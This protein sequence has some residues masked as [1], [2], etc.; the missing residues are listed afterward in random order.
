MFSTPQAAAAATPKEL[1]RYTRYQLRSNKGPVIRL[2][3]EWTQRR[4][5]V[6][7]AGLF[8]VPVTPAFREEA[9]YDAYLR[10]SG[11]SEA[12]ILQNTYVM[13]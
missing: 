3:K 11:K 4:R 10:N 9:E 1:V 12:W 6:Y 7:I 2:D 8:A 13:Y 5:I